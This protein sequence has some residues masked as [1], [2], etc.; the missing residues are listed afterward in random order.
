MTNSLASRQMLTTR[1][2]DQVDRA[3]E[4][5]R[6]L[7]HHDMDPSLPAD[8]P[9]NVVRKSQQ[10]KARA[11]AGRHIDKALAK[12]PGSDEAKASRKSRLIDLPEGTPP[13]KRGKRAG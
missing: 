8:A 6:P 1:D 12:V 3:A 11:V 5:G 13:K 2:S 7:S 4:R 9:D 10:V